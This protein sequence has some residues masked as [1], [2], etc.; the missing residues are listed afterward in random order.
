VQFLFNLQPLEI[1]DDDHVTGVRVVET[2]LGHAGFDARQR[3]ENVSGTEQF[4]PAHAVIIAVGF[5]AS[6]AD[7]FSEFDI[8][9]RPNGLVRAKSSGR[10]PFQ[11]T[12]PKVFA[13]GYMVRS[14]DLVVTAVFDE[15]A[16]A[17]GIAAF[18]GV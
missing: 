8:G 6:P 15:R 13:D 11:T 2:R 12:N 14:A 17:A 4:L 5:G 9:L 1:V 18:L 10:V 16:A 3:P 7:W